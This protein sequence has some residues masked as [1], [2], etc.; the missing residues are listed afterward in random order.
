MTGFIAFI[1]GL[2]AVI[3]S[4]LN[5]FFWPVFGDF[6]AATTPL[7]EDCRLNFAA[8]S[9]IHMKDETARRDMLAFGLQDMENSQHSLDALICAGD[10]TDHGEKEEW[11]MLA[12][13]FSGYTPAENIILT[14][15][16]HDT[17]TGDDDYALSVKHFI[18]YN[19]VI[20]GREIEKVYYSTKINGYT[21]IVMGSE[22][23]HTYAVFSQEQIDWLDK[24]M[25]TASK[26]GLPIFVI[27]H[28]PINESHG[29]PVTWGDDE[30]EPDDGGMGDQSAQVEEVLK[31]YENVFL[32]SGHIHNGL[33]N[34]SQEDVYDYVSVESDGSFHSVNLPSYMYLSIRGRIANGTGLNFEVYD[35][36]VVIRARSYSAGVWYTDYNYT[37][38]LV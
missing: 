8:I 16:N 34:E 13:A 10:L 15:G 38:E 6:T 33:T 4:V 29:L 24:E 3:M 23:D 35:D 12:E 11:E 36:E 32:I 1:K 5:F 30:P 17:W 7:K 22:S 28:W 18:E 2:V 27:S 26:D 31:K 21:F 25:E 19:E 14:Q 9:D 20:A 37:I